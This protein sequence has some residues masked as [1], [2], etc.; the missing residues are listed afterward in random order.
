MLIDGSTHEVRA[1][2]ATSARNCHWLALVPGRKVY[3]AHKEAP[4]LTVIDLVGQR[5]E[6]TIEV[7]GGAEE[8]DA[9]PEGDY[10]YSVTPRMPVEV[11][12]ASGHFFRPERK[13]GDPA[14][15]VVKIDVE[16]NAVVAE[17]EF[18]R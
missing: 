9:A 18:E 8:V 16:T 7:P 1:N 2:I 4:I 12:L 15:R 6:A 17:I 13:D 5:V 10:V 11:D 3:V 14:P